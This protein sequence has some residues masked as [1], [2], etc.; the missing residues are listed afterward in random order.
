M[1][2]AASLFSATAMGQ[3]NANQPQIGYLYPSGGQAG[4]VVK[5][6]AGGQFLRGAAEVYVSGEGV[7]GKVI[8]YISPLRNLQKE[9]RELLQQRF[10]EV[11]DKRLAELPPLP[12]TPRPRRASARTT[13][14]NKRAAAATAVADKAGEA[15]KQSDAKTPEVKLP[16][17]PLL[18]DL[19]NKSLR[20]LAHI[21]TILFFPRTKLQMNRQ[22]SEMVLIEITVDPDAQPGRRELRLRTATGLTNPM[23]FEVAML[24][25]V[26][27]LEPN[28]DQ[29]YPPLPG[30]AKVANLPKDKPLE[31]PVLLNGQIMPGDVDRFRFRARQ[32]QKLVIDA[33]ARSLIPYLADAVPGWFQ[34]T[35]ALYDARGREVAF[36]DDYRFNPDPVLL[37]QIPQTGEYEL[38]IRDSVYRG[39]EDFVYRVAVSEQP[40][41][42]QMFPLGGPAGVKTVA[43]VDGWNLETTE[44]PLDTQSGGATIRQTACR[45]EELLSNC[46]SYAVDTL[47]E[48]DEVES[49]D[50]AGEA[51]LIEMPKIING[52]ID[53]P[54]DI[55]V[56][57]FEGRT[58]EKIVA[59]V[60]ARRLNSPLDSLL[61]LTD[62]TGSVL[63]WNDDYVLKESHLYTNIAGLMT[64]HADSYLLAELPSDGTY[65]V[66]LA[67]SQNHGGQVHGYRLRI[68]VAQG[69][70]ALRVTPSSLSMRA[71][72][73]ATLDIHALRKDGFDGPIEVFLDDTSAGFELGGSTIPTGCD[74]VR[75]TLKSPVKAPD[76]PVPLGL[77]GR[78]RIAGGLVVRSAFAADDCMQAFL[79]RHLV[80][81]QQF[82]VCVQPGRSGMPAVEVPTKPVRIAAGGSGR[83]LL[84]TRKNPALQQ[85]QFELLD[86]PEGLTLD[87]VVV[88]P[89]GI[90]FELKADKDA[91]QNGFA[92]NLIVEVF[93]QST[94]KQQPGKPKPQKRRYS[95]GI[96]PAIPI[97]IV[98]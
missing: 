69:D 58:G 23:V 3:S 78:A 44:L 67:D 87:G 29:A 91:M 40:F 96:L 90:Q 20:E 13:T 74:H 6:T 51:Q 8:E 12:G 85:M 28:N 19:D 82:L 73:L 94:P 1:F 4:V 48:C 98:Q 47:A 41:I 37:Y 86:P 21:S 66:H 34:A 95:L 33:H 71:G 54:G 9:Q 17:H 32:G 31:L 93:R 65:Y 70:F 75:M 16:N 55:D 42:T 49:N 72:G 62:A 25:E 61:R 43:S 80:P 7:R 11:R 45:S 22:L 15:K 36:V 84:K 18:H 35:L 27:E 10:K 76:K 79:Y 57:R 77:A 26:R 38:E 92:G 97:E 63:A 30:L 83:V 46:V 59:E 14:A 2:V 5:I 88:V 53:R 50:S 68:A 89:E 52:R 24:P 81:A 60:Y 64:H 39:R 56:F